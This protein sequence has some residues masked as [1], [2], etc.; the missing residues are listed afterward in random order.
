[1]VSVLHGVADPLTWTRSLSLSGNEIAIARTVQVVWCS[2]DPVQ[3]CTRGWLRQALRM[4]WHSAPRFA[5]SDNG[6]PR[7]PDPADCR[8]SLGPSEIGSE[9]ERASLAVITFLSFR[10]VYSRYVTSRE[11][12]LTPGAPYN[13]RRLIYSVAIDNVTTPGSFDTLLPIG[14]ADYKCEIIR[15][16]MLRFNY[17]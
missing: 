5:V 15:K 1:M 13:R 14:I 3:I 6:D 17:Q 10:A 12:V 8:N 4:R 7:K 9:W 2:L 16:G 11:N